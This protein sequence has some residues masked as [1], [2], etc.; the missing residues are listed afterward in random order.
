[1]YMVYRIKMNVQLCFVPPCSV[2]KLLFSVIVS[3]HLFHVIH[4]FHYH[5]I[6]HSRFVMSFCYSDSDYSPMK[7]L[8]CM[9]QFISNI[10]KKNFERFL[11]DFRTGMGLVQKGND[12]ISVAI[13][14][15]VVCTLVY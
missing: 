11:I 14:E 7:T 2:E 10:S 15:S 5:A 1:M 13:E 3:C 8:F 4:C 12:Q 9:S 6:F